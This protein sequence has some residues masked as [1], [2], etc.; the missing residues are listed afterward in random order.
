MLFSI[1]TTTIHM[2][3]MDYEDAHTMRMN[4]FDVTKVW[5]HKEFPL[6]EVRTWER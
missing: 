3:M 1:T 6:I 2:Q 5:S 4:P